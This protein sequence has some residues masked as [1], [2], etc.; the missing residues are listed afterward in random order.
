MKNTRLNCKKGSLTVDFIFAFTLVMGLSAILLSFSLTLTAASI[1]QYM[2]FVS[3]RALFAADHDRDMQSINAN[4]QYQRVLNLPVFAPLFNGGWFA[5]NENART[6]IDKDQD[7][8]QIPYFRDV[9]VG[10]N[11]PNL[12]IGSYTNFVARILDFH[13]PFYGST[14]NSPGDS[15][16]FTTMIGTFLSAEPTTLWCQNFNL[17]RWPAI[18]NL[19]VPSGSADYRA[20]PSNLKYFYG[21]NDNGC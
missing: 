19:N 14:S 4:E 18:Q 9:P 10:N 7:T 11:E 21:M 13:I 6:S 2:T 20:M 17:S 12:F 15:S 5:V 8:P 16:G 3:A 1:T